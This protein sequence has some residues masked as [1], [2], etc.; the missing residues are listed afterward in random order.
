MQVLYIDYPKN[1]Y[2]FVKYKIPKFILHV[3][4]FRNSQLPENDFLYECSQE[5]KAAVGHV[6]EALKEKQEEY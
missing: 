1:E 3:L 2:E 6:D 5:K 4:L